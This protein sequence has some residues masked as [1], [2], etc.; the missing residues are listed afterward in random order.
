MQNGWNT[1][2]LTFAMSDEEIRETFG[3]GTLVEQLTGVGNSDGVCIKNG[4]KFVR[5]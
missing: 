4:R 2:C 5:K 1:I 3:E